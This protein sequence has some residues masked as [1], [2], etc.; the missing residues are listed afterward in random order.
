MDLSEQRPRFL[1]DLVKDKVKAL[2]VAQDVLDRLE[3]RPGRVQRHTYGEG[4]I[5]LSPDELREDL[6]VQQVV[7]KIEKSCSTCLLGACL[8][9]KARLYDE[10]KLSELSTYQTVNGISPFGDV[11][12][13]FRREAV[14]GS[15]LP[16]FG[17]FEMDKLE[18]FFE[19]KVMGLVDYDDEGEY[20]DYMRGCAEAGR[21]YDSS[22]GALVAALKNFIANDG[23]LTVT[24]VSV[25]D[26]SEYEEWDDEDDEDEDD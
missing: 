24:P 8:L 15:L 20:A 18:S 10:L 11:F 6:E 21:E 19:G 26:Y 22:E 14:D 5:T 3:Y 4:R 9:S 17:R 13:H 7:D 12:L 23:C 16:I 2:A 1:A 25:D